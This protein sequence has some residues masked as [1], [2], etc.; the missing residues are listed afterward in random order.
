MWGYFQTK[1]KLHVLFLV[2]NGQD[3]SQQCVTTPMIFRWVPQ[4]HDSL[5]KPFRAKFLHQSDIWLVVWYMAFIYP[6]IRNVIIP[7]DEL[8]F[9]RGVGEPPTRYQWKS[10]IF[11]QDR[12]F[13]CVHLWMVASPCCLARFSIF[14]YFVPVIFKY[15]FVVKN[16]LIC[17]WKEAI[18]PLT[19]IYLFM[20]FHFIYGMSSFPL[21]FIFFRGVGIPPTRY[22][23][24]HH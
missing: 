19:L 1:T 23:I 8:I 17:F 6:Y 2:A 11:W 18:P 10:D 12:H 24:N 5:N 14:P 7:T 15:M 21:T 13:P 20:F 9:F 16:R 22:I 3:S 4:S